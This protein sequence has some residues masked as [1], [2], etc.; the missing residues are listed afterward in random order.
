MNTST[1]RRHFEGLAKYI[2]AFA[3]LVS[4]TGCES[5]RT[6]I[7]VPFDVAKLVAVKAIEIPYDAAKTTALGVYTAATQ[8]G[9]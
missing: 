2:I 8:A 5:G 1:H 3:A 7:S 9:R 6:L 4:L